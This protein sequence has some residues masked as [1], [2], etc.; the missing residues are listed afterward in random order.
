MAD[1]TARYAR[2]N[3]AWFL[4]LSGDLRHALAPAVNALLDRA[5]ADPAFQ[6]CVIDM[7]AVDMIDSTCLGVLARIAN[8][9]QA[10]GLEQPTIIAPNADVT[11]LLASVCFDQMF[12]LEPAA[13]EPGTPLEQ[14]P[15]VEVSKDDARA[16]VLEAHRRL[17]A[18]DARTH[19]A[20]KDLVAALES[21][22]RPRDGQ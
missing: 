16:L 7:T 15:P 18:I 9:H 17:C 4:K 8:H 21:A 1:S 6:C 20:F 14:V 2:D 5:F 11:L 10:V 13:A 22:Q 12:H 19:D 3:G